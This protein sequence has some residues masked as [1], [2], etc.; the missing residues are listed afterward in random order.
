M[1][2]PLQTHNCVA[3]FKRYLVSPQLSSVLLIGGVPAVGGEAGR[4]VIA[5]ACRTLSAVISPEE[6]EIV[7]LDLQ[8]L[9]LSRPSR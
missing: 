1:S 7:C 5:R 9:L 6:A 2:S 3:D 8:L 4:H